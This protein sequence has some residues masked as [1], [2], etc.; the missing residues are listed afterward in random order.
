MIPHKN[1]FLCCFLFLLSGS[2]C[3][4]MEKKADDSI[5]Q[6]LKAHKNMLILYSSLCLLE[7]STLAFDK[8][9][10]SSNIGKLICLCLPYYKF[11]FMSLLT[12]YGLLLK[13][14]RVPI[15]NKANLREHHLQS[16][17]TNL[18]ALIKTQPELK[19]V[20]HI[21]RQLSLDSNNITLVLGC[22]GTGA[23]FKTIQIAQNFNEEAPTTADKVALF[24]HELCHITDKVS[25]RVSNLNCIIPLSIDCALLSLL[26]YLRSEVPSLSVSTDVLKDAWPLRLCGSL[27][28]ATPLCHYMLRYYEKKAD[29]VSARLGKTAQ[30]FSDYMYKCHLKISDQLAGKKILCFNA[31]KVNQ[32]FDEHPASLDR[33]RYL[34]DVAIKEQHVKPQDLMIY[35]PALTR[36][37]LE[38]Q[39]QDRVKSLKNKAIKCN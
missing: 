34:A 28:I 18:H 23:I 22:E 16:V 24:G 19:L 15:N 39:L 3:L 25:Q 6:Q 27:L 33:A 36:T 20:E 4:P 8:I 11:I 17:R 14:N 35:N 31:L 1:I 7:M 13:L 12:W 9:S 26:T 5:M 2:G 29:L 10:P 38:S 32:F 30:A 37:F 21:T